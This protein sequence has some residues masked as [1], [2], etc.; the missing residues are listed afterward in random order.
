MYMYIYIYTYIHIYMYIYIEREIYICIYT[1]CLPYYPEQGVP[2]IGSP[3]HLRRVLRRVV[4]HY[5]RRGRH[6]LLHHALWGGTARL[7][8]LV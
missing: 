2:H 5:Q 3:R 8:L 6:G 7:S 1:L 4:R